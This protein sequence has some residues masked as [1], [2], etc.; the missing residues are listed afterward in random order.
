MRELHA[1][2]M[3]FS[4]VRVF[5]DLSN[6]QKRATKSDT[7]GHCLL[8]PAC[9]PLHENI[10]GAHCFGCKRANSKTCCCKVLDVQNRTEEEAWGLHPFGYLCLLR[11]WKMDFC[12]FE[13]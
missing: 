10:D 3:Q 4:H 9:Q 1:F 8:G 2:H 11:N 5:S 13:V 7:L 6:V 12:V